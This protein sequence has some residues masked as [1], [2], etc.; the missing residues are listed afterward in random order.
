MCASISTMSEQD[1][2]SDS[3]IDSV[4]R[5]CSREE[6]ELTK[7]LLAPYTGRYMKVFDKCENWVSIFCDWLITSIEDENMSIMLDIENAWRP[8][9]FVDKS[10][11]K[12]VDLLGVKLCTVYDISVIMFLIAKFLWI[13]ND[14]TM[15]YDSAIY[16]WRKECTV[17]HYKRWSM[18][19]IM[20]SL[21]LWWP[22]W[23]LVDKRILIPTSTMLR[24]W[25]FL[26]HTIL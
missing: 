20:M 5:H 22:V 15:D 19:C 23:R 13:E 18:L 24:G 3:F 9:L 10:V 6:I 8:E 26:S 21:L 25:T 4:N 11:Q 12:V 7:E 16:G 14:L 17:Q 2:Y 1:N